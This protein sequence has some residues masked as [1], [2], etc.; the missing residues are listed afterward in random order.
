MDRDEVR[1]IVLETLET[2][3]DLQIRAVQELKGKVPEGRETLPRRGRRRQS[4]V[5]MSV[6]ILTEQEGALHV[7]DLVEE[8]RTRYGRLTDRDSLSSALAKKARSGVLFRQTAP[9]TFGL[10]DAEEGKP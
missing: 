5:D 2:Y 7:S 10:L 3:T 4:L 8:L 1:K 6:E 9:A